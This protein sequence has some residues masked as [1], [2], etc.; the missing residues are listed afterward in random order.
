MEKFCIEGGIPLKGEIAPSGNKNAAIP[1]LTAC[2][3]TEEPVILHNMP[4]IKNVLRCLAEFQLDGLTSLI[5]NLK[6][7]VNNNEL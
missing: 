2:L 1:L 4:L 5:K 6:I 7:E 3:L